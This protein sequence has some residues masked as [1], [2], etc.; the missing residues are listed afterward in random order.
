MAVLNTYENKML[1]QIYLIV[2]S[3]LVTSLP[4][5]IWLNAQQFS[6]AENKA[7]VCNIF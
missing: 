7:S 4:L 6:I 3:L 5:V 2:Y 1:I